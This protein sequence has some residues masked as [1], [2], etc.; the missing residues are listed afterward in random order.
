M[1]ITYAEVTENG[2]LYVSLTIP[3]L[4]VGTVGGGTWLPA[5]RAALS[6]MGVAGSGDPPGTN[7]RRFA[8]IVAAA[9]LAGELSLLAALSSHHLVE[10]HE[11]LGRAKR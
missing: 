1:A 7:A 3:S 6:L 9:A 11:R 8:E 2:D 10:A 4:E 5:Q